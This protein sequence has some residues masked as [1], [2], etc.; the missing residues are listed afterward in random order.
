M[1]AGC[2][3][4][5]ER[6]GGC[7]FGGV[8]NVDSNAHSPKNTKK[9][10]SAKKKRSLPSAQDASPAL[11]HAANL[12]SFYYGCF[13]S[14]SRE[15][16]LIVLDKKTRKT[17]LFQI[18]FYPLVRRI[19][20]HLLMFTIR[21]RFKVARA[22][23]ILLGYLWRRRA[24]RCSLLEAHSARMPACAKRELAAP[25]PRPPPSSH[26]HALAALPPT[27]S[28]PPLPPVFFRGNLLST[29]L[30]G[31]GPAQTA[32]RAPAQRKTPATAAPPR[33]I[34]QRRTAEMLKASA[35]SAKKAKRIVSSTAPPPQHARPRA[36]E[37]AVAP[38]KISDE[39][40]LLRITQGNTRA[41]SG[42]TH[43]SITYKDVI[44]RGDRPASPS[45]Q[46][47][48]ETAASK[49]WADLPSAHRQ[50]Q[51]E[52][53]RKISAPSPTKRRIQ[54]AQRVF[55][56]EGFA[57]AGA[58]ATENDPPDRAPKGILARPSLP[59]GGDPPAASAAH[60]LPVPVQRTLYVGDMRSARPKKAA[61][62][63][64]GRRPKEA[65]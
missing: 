42:Y 8:E 40:E 55:F 50:I 25:Q 63:A 34:V 29:P 1:L 28:S 65:R 7:E 3:G 61:V 4:E 19:L 39:A 38:R 36:G 44:V 12:I 20:A 62:A 48:K 41:N 54:W 11:R 49:R 60:R 14:R 6:E 26:A 24:A 53:E 45:H 17:L 52:W 10:K 30:R 23:F 31:L 21:R 9:T 13:S 59:P 2:E 57:G 5:R 47:A 64:A 56:I 18:C 58:A 32:D 15:A 51:E 46:F 33:S 27:S 22:G 37:Q 35:S 43:A 16:G